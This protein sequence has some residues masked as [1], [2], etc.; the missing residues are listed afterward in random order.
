MR[1]KLISLW[2]I[3]ACI[4]NPAKF[5]LISCTKP[6]RVMGS[7]NWKTFCW[8]EN[9]SPLAHNTRHRT[10]NVWNLLH[11]WKN[12]PE[13]HIKLTAEGEH[14]RFPIEI[15]YK[16]EVERTN[17]LSFTLSRNASTHWKFHSWNNMYLVFVIF[18]WHAQFLVEIFSTQK[19]R[20]SR[21]NWFCD[22]V[23]KLKNIT[24]FTTTKHGFYIYGGILRIT[25]K[26]KCGEISN[27]SIS[28]MRR[29]L[30]SLHIYHA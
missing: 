10:L 1:V 21:Q 14:W 13:F 16:M 25:H 7:K 17:F 28:V 4:S 24:N 6:C 19:A 18:S 5:G 11:F 22:K 8:K 20:R 29:N 12:S 3:L 9:P 26:A 27:F 2:Q 15:L 30:K 23:R